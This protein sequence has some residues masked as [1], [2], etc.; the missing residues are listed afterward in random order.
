MNKRFPVI[1]ADPPWR[2]ECWTDWK[3]D[4]TLKES[5]ASR[6]VENQYQ[7]QGYDWLKSLP[8]ADVAAKDCCLFLWVTWPV[9]RDALRLI[10]A[11]GFTYKT[12]GFDWVKVTG[13]GNAAMKLGYWT[14]ANT[15][16]C[17]LAT[18]GKP[19]RV[20]KGVSQVIV[21]GTGAHSEKPEEMY[22][23]IERLVEGPYLELFHRPRNG[24]FGPRPNWTFLGNEV[25][26][27]DMRDA[28]AEVAGIA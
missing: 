26:G 24:M 6:R 12:L 2:F 22:E 13:D 16:P 7:T 25:D 11:W 28:L 9:M 10:E 15:E 1:V 8:V 17:L 3:D 19:K 27:K 23:R 4:G 18:R 5:T 21:S 20:D 14:R